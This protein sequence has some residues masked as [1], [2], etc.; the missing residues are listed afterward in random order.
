[1]KSPPIKLDQARLLQTAMDQISTNIMITD[2]NLNINY[3][4]DHMV[5]FLT[6]K[7]AVLQSALPQ[8]KVNNLLGEN[9]DVFIKILRINVVY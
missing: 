5:K 9:I 1:L 2:A 6:D 4:N 7:E 8:F 3:M